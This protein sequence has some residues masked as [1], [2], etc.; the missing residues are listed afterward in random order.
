MK[1]PFLF[2]GLLGA[3]LLCGFSGMAPKPQLRTI[4]A[5]DA[6]HL[7]TF[8]AYSPD[9]LPFV[10]AHRGGARKGFPENCLATFE[11]TLGQVHAILEIDPHYTRDSAIVLMHDATLD[12]TSTGHGKV[13][14][15]TLKELQAFKLKDTEGNVTP[16]G[17]PTLDEA[18]DWAKG[19]T[20]LVLDKKDVPIEARVRKIEQHRAEAHAIVM[21]YSFEEAKTCYRLNKKMLMEVMFGTLEKVRAFDQT[22]VPWQNVVVFVSH[23]LGIDP[24][25]F[26][27]IHQ[28]GAMCMV[29]SSRNYDMQYAKGEIKSVD[30]L[31][32]KYLSIIDSGA[33]I[34]EA[35][36]AIE[37]GTAL[38]PLQNRTSSKAL[39]FR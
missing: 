22:G 31:N 36:L 17:I 8:F 14:D 33:D 37:A 3:A 18:L 4:R 30:E 39:Y 13:A 29:G 23:N 27:E 5:R 7:K 2:A 28:R 20:I 12:R 32:R 9:R 11:N 21:A 10:S 26:R 24:A 6:Q 16:Y 35:D 34:I 25:V 15:Y 38:K 19:K 1:Y